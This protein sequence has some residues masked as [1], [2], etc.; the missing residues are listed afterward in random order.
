MRPFST[1]GVGLAWLFLAWMPTS[2]VLGFRT[3]AFHR[4]RPVVASTHSV[5]SDCSSSA[6]AGSTGTAV[7]RYRRLLNR[8]GDDQPLPG[9]SIFHATFV[10]SS[11]VVGRF[12]AAAWP[13]PAGPRNWGQSAADS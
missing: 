8:L 2:L 3:S 6:L 12:L 11:N 1:S 4:I 9:I 10:V 5:R 13:S 7:V